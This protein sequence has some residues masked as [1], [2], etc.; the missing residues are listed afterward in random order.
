MSLPL[1]R[2]ARGRRR[3]VASLARALP[4]VSRTVATLVLVM[5]CGCGE[6]PTTPA[7]PR[8]LVL[9][10]T[11][12]PLDRAREGQYEAW[13]TD[14]SGGFHSLGRFDAGGT[15]TLPAPPTGATSVVVSLEPPVGSGTQP[16]EQVVLRGR[17]VGDQAELRYEGAI[18]QSDLALVGAPGQFTMFSPSDNDSLG[19]PSHEESGVWLFNMDPGQTAQKDYYV[20]VTQLQRGW[21]Y[22]G[23]M[24]RDLGQA[25]A[26]WLSYGKF[27]PDWTGALNQPDDTGWGP[28]SGVVDFRR[29]RL[30]DFPGDDWISNPLH[31]PWNAELTLPL[32]LRE[33]DAQGRLRW[34]HVI[35]IEP[36][37]D[38]GE[39]IGAERPFFLRPY[40]DSFGDLPPGAARTITFRAETL[41]HGTAAVQ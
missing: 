17:L 20:R 10:T 19:Y 4:G 16:S 3:A 7:G 28:F 21:T 33:K 8:Q 5:A 13:A 27:V 24:V 12:P 37:S 32:N 2:P 35:T 18:T 38:L 31:L 29:A 15:L 41:P 11:L 25:S 39:A 23:W 36:A 40:V 34:S 6:G 30:E 1:W 26:I 22:E 14:A 9:V